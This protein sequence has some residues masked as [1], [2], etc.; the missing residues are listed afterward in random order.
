MN[1]LTP[2]FPPAT[3]PVRKGWYL[4]S[5]MNDDSPYWWVF[6]YWTGKRWRGAHPTYWRGVTTTKLVPP[7]SFALIVDQ[8][9]NSTI[10]IPA[11]TKPT[12]PVPPTFALAVTSL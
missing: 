7:D 8:K 10:L 5:A 2:W 12:D 11:S 1:L 4:T 3:K 6:T 9:D